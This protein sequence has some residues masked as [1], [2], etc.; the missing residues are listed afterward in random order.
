MRSTIL[1]CNAG[2]LSPKMISRID[3]DQ[4]QKGC[5]KLQNF[6]ITPYG[7]IERRPGTT[8]IG[9]AKSEDVRLIS[10]IFSSKI[11]Y[12]CEFGENYIAFYRNGESLD[13]ILA[14]PYTVEDL[15][16]IKHIQSA[17]VM[18]IVHPDY[19]VHE[20]RRI[21]EDEFE[22]IEKE[23]IYPP[24][25][26]INSD[27]HKNLMVSP[28]NE[29]DSSLLAGTEVVLH[30]DFNAF[31]EESVGTYYQLTHSRSEN[32]LNYDFT[33]DDVSGVIE[34]YG[35]WTFSTHGTWNGTL[36]IERSE[37]YGDTWEIFKTCTSAADSNYI[38]SYE[39]TSEEIY[40]RLRMTDYV[41]SDTGTIKFCRTQISNPGF[42][43]QGVAKITE[44]ISTTEALA[45]VTKRIYSQDWTNEWA[46]S[47]FSNK[48]G[49][50]KT[51]A[52][53]EERLVLA[54]NNKSPNR[55]FFSKTNEWD[56]FLVGANANDGIDITLASNTVNE[57]S[58]ILSQNSLVIGTLDSEW[59]L[60]TD[61]GAA[62]TPANMPGAMLQSVFGSA[63]LPAFIAGDTVLFVQ[64]KN[65]KLREFIY[66]ND[67]QGYAV[68]DLTAFAEHITDSGIKEVALQQLPDTIVW[69]VLNDGTI[70]TLTY[71]SSQ[72][73]RGWAKQITEGKIISAAVLPTSD[74]EDEV[75]WA[76][77][78]EEGVYIEKMSARDSGNY[79]DS[80]DMENLEYTSIYSPMPLETQLEQGFS[81]HMRKKIS[82]LT[83]RT[84]NSIGGSIQVN[85][86]KEDFIVAHD[87]QED[88]LIS[89]IS[90][91]SE[92]LEIAPLGEYVRETD[93][94]IKQTGNLPLNIASLA[95]TFDVC[96]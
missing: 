65:R 84:Y 39:E 54:G 53:Y 42:M 32:E 69:C 86:G 82:R 56:N 66:S 12:I 27:D 19:P 8:Y 13:L 77:R 93:I 51:I 21:A 78:R 72:G 67:K 91:K 11:A 50:P 64:R 4:Y 35:A 49:F 15:P 3:V 75:Y 22:F 31:T 58:W 28:C 45:T 10:F 37:D 57:I 85:G 6:L 59:V 14:T 74:G 25:L 34:V 47:A 26:D 79:I 43:V 89:D 46:E 1:A 60:G 55:I 17:D 29:S 48:N 73:V 33:K 92:V 38:E 16:K 90:P 7:A 62:L 20:L 71:E 41:K 5:K 52:F 94:I 83:L 68:S 88:N 24:M 40:Y 76:V 36:Y 96:E 23:F 63:N 95:I 70:A 30:A 81:L 9:T 18:Y 2:E 44:Y 61:D 80:L 87:I